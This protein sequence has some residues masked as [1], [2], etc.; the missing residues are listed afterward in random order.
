[1]TQDR[2]QQA[3][4]VEDGVGQGRRLVLVEWADSYGVSS[5][6][7]SV[8]DIEAVP[9]VVRSVGWVV[10]ENGELLV[11]VPHLADAR[12][13]GGEE[14]GCGDMTIP[15]SAVRR[16]VDLTPVVEAV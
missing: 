13:H 1:M 11:V 2:H 16:L 5:V 12:E 4:T 7:Q 15:K 8:E 3:T 14:Q 6:W 10:F 9:L